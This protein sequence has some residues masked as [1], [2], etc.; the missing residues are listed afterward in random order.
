MQDN[1]RNAV[2]CAKHKNQRASRFIVRFG[3]EIFKRF[4][5][6]E[7]ASRFL[8]GV[9]F[10]KDEGSY[11]SRD[12]KQNKPLGFESLSDQWLEVKKSQVK[13]HSWDTL[14]NV[15]RKAGSEWGNRNI[16]E[17]G[18]AEIE[19]FLYKTLSG[20]STKTR[21]NAKSVLNS[22]FD[23]LKKRRILNASQLPEIP[24]V[25]YEL[26]FRKTLSKQV[27]QEVLSE[28]ERL[29]RDINPRIWIAICWLST[30][31]SIRPGELIRIK[32]GEVDRQNGFLIIPHPKEKKP[33]IVPLT[34]DDLNLVRSMTQGFPELPFF[35]H[36]ESRSG[37]QAGE[38]FGPRYL[39]K[40]WKKATDNLG[41]TDVDLYGGTRHST[42]IYLG[43][44]FTPEEIKQATFHTTNKAFERYFRVQ[45]DVVKGLYTQAQG[46]NGTVLSIRTPDTP[47]KH[48]VKRAS[49]EI[50]NK[51]GGGGGS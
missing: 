16:K 18:Y 49:A 9:R 7:S 39:Y 50:I 30:Y 10:K 22:F 44:F 33:K 31:I 3:R 42:A 1:G 46:R 48:R 13:R 36:I 27:Q 24:E 5:D 41:I 38:P 45:P 40:W 2:T 12:Y 26:A 17:I 11:D 32:E 28:I 8:N 25:S 20:R 43:E 29:T 34:D 14:N 47:V 19:D 21:A 37:V 6:Y 15:M 23:W 4:T 51:I 35:R